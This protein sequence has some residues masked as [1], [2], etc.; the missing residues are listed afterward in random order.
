MTNDPSLVINSEICNGKPFKICC[1]QKNGKV[2]EFLGHKLHMALLILMVSIMKTFSNVID[3]DSIFA[4]NQT[5]YTVSGC[6]RPFAVQTV[7]IWVGLDLDIYNQM[8]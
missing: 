3:N 8:K 2:C 1:F 6:F 5:D 7:F 4:L